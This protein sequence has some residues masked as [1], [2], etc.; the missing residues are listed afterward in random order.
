ML[1]EPS[2]QMGDLALRGSE[3]PFD[4][5]TGTGWPNHYRQHPLV[6]INASYTTR[7][8]FHRLAS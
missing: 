6:D 7:Y 1:L 2:R 4:V 3:L 8:L 5:F